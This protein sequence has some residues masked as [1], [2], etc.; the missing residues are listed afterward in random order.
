M[1][2]LQTLISILIFYL[3]S[4][5]STLSYMGLGYDVCT[6]EGHIAQTLIFMTLIFVMSLVF[7]S[8]RIFYHVLVATVLFWIL[9]HPYTYGLVDKMI[10]YGYR[11]FSEQGL[12]I[13]SLVY[14]ILIYNLY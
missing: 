13:H 6:T 14:G 12:M 7:G 9:S 10:G 8:H 11:C 1:N 3:A 2:I 5:P 4:Q